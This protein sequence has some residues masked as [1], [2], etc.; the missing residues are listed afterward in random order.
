[1]AVKTDAKRR[2]WLLTMPRTA[3][4]LLVTILNL[5]EQGVRPCYHGGYFF[6]TS[7]MARLSLYHKP[8]S[9][10]TPEQRKIVDDQMRENFDNLQDYLEAAEEGDQKILVKEHISF[11]NNPAFES[12]YMYGA[13]DGDDASWK[14]VLPARH[15]ASST[16]SS[17]NFTVLPDEFLKT[18]HPTFLIRHPA[19][20]LPSL[21][22]TANHDEMQMDGKGRSQKEPFDVEST[23]KFVRALHEFYVGHFGPDSQWP[24]VLDADDIITHPE[25]VIKYAGMVGL[26]A[27]KLKFSWEKMSPEKLESLPP[28]QRIM[29]QTLSSSTGL[30][31]EKVAGKIC[32][33]EEAKKWKCEFG[34]ETGAKLEKRVNDMMD[35]YEYLHK[36]RGKFGLLEKR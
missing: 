15:G 21:F 23:L 25:L 1:M 36:R 11:L 31:R 13:T 19:K 10:W 2:Y 8:M 26:D 30:L 16:R 6:F 18:W 35:D 3:S 33:A 27:E 22:R 9:E 14:D 34:E 12:E 24:V 4:N 5:T 17:P 7:A 20:M 29:I 28:A 32:I